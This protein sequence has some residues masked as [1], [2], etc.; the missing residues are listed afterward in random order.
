[1]KSRHTILLSSMWCLRLFPYIQHLI[2]CD[3]WITL[4]ATMNTFLQ[5]TV[6]SLEHYITFYF[7]F[8]YL[9]KVWWFSSAQTS[10]V[11]WSEKEKCCCLNL[12]E[13]ESKHSP[14][15]CSCLQENIGPGNMEDAITVVKDERWKR[16]RSTLSPCFTS[17]RMK[18][19][20]IM[21]EH[22]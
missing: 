4:S 7:I 18:K 5:N 17:G 8:L 15:L 12:S 10:I 22:H 3:Q 1:M 9:C 11:I 16:I 6:F 20:G 19:V 21:S 2:A 13:Q 14:E